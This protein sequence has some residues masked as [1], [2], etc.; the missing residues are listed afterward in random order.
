MPAGWI[1]TPAADPLVSTGVGLLR[2]GALGASPLTQGKY[3]EPVRKAASPR[4]REVQT[5]FPIRD[6]LLPAE[7]EIVAHEFLDPISPALLAPRSRPGSAPTVRRIEDPFRAH[8]E[9][10]PDIRT[11]EVPLL[12]ALAARRLEGP[13]L[14]PAGEPNRRDIGAA[15][16]LP[17]AVPIEFSGLLGKAAG[18]VRP[19]RPFNLGTA[20][21]GPARKSRPL[22]RP[23][24]PVRLAAA[25]FP[26]PQPS[27]PASGDL[28]AR[29]RLVYTPAFRRDGRPLT[30]ATNT[31]IARVEVLDTQAAEL[32][33]AGPLVFEHPLAGA[34]PAAVRNRPRGRA[35]TWLPESWAR[36]VRDSAVAVFGSVESRADGVRWPAA[37]ASLFAHLPEWPAKK[38]G[39]AHTDPYGL[40]ALPVPA[41]GVPASADL[42]TRLRGAAVRKIAAPA[43]QPDTRTVTRTAPLSVA[44]YDSG[45]PKH[46]PLF[47]GV[48]RIA[49][50]PGG[51]FHLL[52]FEDHE[53]YGTWSRAPHYE[54]ALLIPGSGCDVRSLARMAAPGY[55]A[56]SGGLHPGAAAHVR[57]YGEF[58]PAS[59]VTVA[60][61][62]VELISM[63]FAAIAESGS[64]RWRLPFK[65]TAMFT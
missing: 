50:F 24:P 12:A 7:R 32:P 61:G 63:D 21:L 16:V 58:P 29:E 2:E 9:S 26:D 49:M 40:Y 6:G 4:W 56:V 17:H 59:H 44:F 18:S 54:A 43:I 11:A 30:V 42:R 37:R 27:E 28:A 23:L 38:G 31:Q 51:V 64:S 19:V 60:E 10:V 65:K 55:F 46:T 45:A 62:L 25:F 1:P 15:R 20:E 57:V 53:D 52:E 36:F 41:A 33:G 3:L 35:T 48:L 13:G 34:P 22:A 14:G 5:P 47:L 39:A 8:A